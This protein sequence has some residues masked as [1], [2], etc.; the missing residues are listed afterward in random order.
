MRQIAPRCSRAQVQKGDVEHALVIYTRE[1]ALQCQYRV[2]VRFL[3]IADMAGPAD[4]FASVENDPGCVKTL[5][6][7]GFSQR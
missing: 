3:G 2:Y 1:A 5:C 4:S 6:F 7:M